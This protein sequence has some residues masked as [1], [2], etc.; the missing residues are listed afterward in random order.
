MLWFIF[1]I[2]IQYLFTNKLIAGCRGEH[3]KKRP[4]LVRYL[5]LLLSL[6][7]HVSNRLGNEMY[8][9]DSLPIWFS[10]KYYNLKNRTVDSFI[11]PL[12]RCVSVVSIE[13]LEKWSCFRVIA[14]I[15][16]FEWNIS[17]MKNWLKYVLIIV[18]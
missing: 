11:A 1:Y 8:S 2:T 17:F 6:F 9:G 5:N 12:L 16:F 14:V 18:L 4:A 13:R 10:I 15:D 3:S 7:A